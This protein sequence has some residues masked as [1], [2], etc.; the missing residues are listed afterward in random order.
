M[1]ADLNVTK[2]LPSVLGFWSEDAV[3]G[4]ESIRVTAVHNCWL[5]TLLLCLGKL[6]MQM[7]K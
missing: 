5:F 1:I 7:D 6:N 3:L 2:Y 4:G